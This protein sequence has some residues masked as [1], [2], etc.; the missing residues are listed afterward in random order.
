M[1]TLSKDASQ[2]G[3]VVIVLFIGIAGFN[4]IRTSWNREVDGQIQQFLDQEYGPV[5]HQYR[6]DPVAFRLRLQQQVQRGELT[7]QEAEELLKV[8]EKLSRKLP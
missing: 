4:C 6:A 5:V 2:W 8:V 7:P 3:W 1:A